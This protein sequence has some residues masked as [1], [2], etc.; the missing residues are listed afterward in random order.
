[1]KIGL[2]ETDILYDEFIQEYRSYGF[3]FEQ[4]FTQLE[5]NNVASSDLEFVYYQ[6]QQ[7]ELPLFLDECDAYVVT[8]SKAGAYEDH[9]WIEPL[10][11]WI[12]EAAQA[13]IK[14]L[15]V[16][17]GH[18]VIAQALGGKVEMSNK[19]WGVGVRSLLTTPDSPFC[20]S[21]P[22][23]LDLIYSHKDQV[24]KL[25][26][27]ARNFLGDDFCPYAGFTIGEHIVTLQGHPEF[28]AE[29]SE[30]LLSRRAKD[31]GDAAYLP[32][33]HSL[34]L[35]TDATYI[36][37]LILDFLSPVKI[38]QDSNNEAEYLQVSNP[39]LAEEGAE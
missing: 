36:G 32:A 33:L 17:F 16:C 6:V 2:L 29:Y 3:M 39:S 28:S 13:E 27:T 14:M 1:M 31:I 9:D 38:Q 25:P 11:N 22:K 23:H 30:Q 21:L 26:P 35:G 34:K 8:G 19:G 10:S 7:G 4:Y 37:R 18:Q 24:V 20:Q 5:G 15:G 12:V